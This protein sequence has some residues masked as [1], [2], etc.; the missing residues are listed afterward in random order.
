M[1]G[2]LEALLLNIFNLI[3]MFP[4]GFL[5]YPVLEYLSLFI[6]EFNGFNLIT[7][8]I[9]NVQSERIIWEKTINRGRLFIV[10]LTGFLFSL[11]IE[12]CQLFLRR[13]LCELDDLF[14]NTLGCIIGSLTY[15]L[16][17]H[18]YICL[19]DDKLEKLEKREL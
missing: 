12:L 6:E 11:M 16:F 7:K 1:H 5:L 19:K 17:R 18:I 3:M 4:V 14:N 2:N 8:K 9:S 10:A 15:T 13:G